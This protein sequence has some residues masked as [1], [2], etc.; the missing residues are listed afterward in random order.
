[1]V[2]RVNCSQNKINTHR[3]LKAK[4]KN[5]CN[6]KYT[7]PSTGDKLKLSYE[8]FEEINAIQFFQNLL[9]NETG[10]QLIDITQYS[11][12]DFVFYLEYYDPDDPDEYDFRLAQSTQ[13]HNKEMEKIRS[14]SSA[15]TT[16][17]MQ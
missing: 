4:W 5:I 15:V 8:D 12:A 1:M 16:A 10:S 11:R 2:V 13:E 7:D 3:K 9:Q 17:P 6:L 14:Q